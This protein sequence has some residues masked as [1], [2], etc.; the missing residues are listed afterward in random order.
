MLKRA[1]DK[2]IALLRRI[3]FVDSHW[4]LWVYIFFG[5]LTTVF[6]W[7]VYFLADLGLGYVMPPMEAP[8]FLGFLFG[9]DNLKET[10][11]Q[12]VSWVLSVAFAFFTNRAFVFHDTSRGW[13]MLAKLGSF[14]ASRLVSG[15]LF[16]IFGFALLNGAL[17]TW[18]G[19]NGY[20]GFIAKIVTS[21]LVIIVNYFFSKF[22]IFRKK[23][24]ASADALAGTDSGSTPGESDVAP[25]TEGS[26]AEEK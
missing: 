21:V 3:S 8:G 26:S 9:G 19:D 22:L 1:F 18:L 10:V 5:G 13:S 23:P 25:P 12:T 2:C 4:E 17:D 15:L 24:A 11:A 16:E 6:S 14:Y 7:I 20:N